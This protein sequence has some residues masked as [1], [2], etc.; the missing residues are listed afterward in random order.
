MQR[1]LVDNVNTSVPNIFPDSFYKIYPSKNVGRH[2]Q[3]FIS[4]AS[5]YKCVHANLR[6][7]FFESKGRLTISIKFDESFFVFRLTRS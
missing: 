6:Q 5:L 2:Q 7:K 3:I 1:V 4:F